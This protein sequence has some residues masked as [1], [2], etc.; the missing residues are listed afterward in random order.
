MTRPK[1]A[2]F[3]DGT[4][5][6]PYWEKLVL[7]CYLRSLGSTQVQAA[8][9]IGRRV[10]AV[11]GWEAQTVLWQRGLDAARARWLGEITALAKRRL[12]QAMMTADGKLALDLLERLDPALAPPAHRLKHEGTVA[13]TQ[14]P[15]WQALR[16]AIL[17]AL[18]DLPEARL[19]L[20]AVLTGDP[21]ARGGYHNGTST[22]AGN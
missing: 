15:E 3:D 19:R 10:R 6:P 12:L 9:A 22:N 1:T 17:Q 14:Q 7:A 4:P 5:R 13:L 11:R 18:A 21:G 16:T 20:A 2:A 8:A